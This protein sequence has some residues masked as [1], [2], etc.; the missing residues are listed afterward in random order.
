MKKIFNL[1]LAGSSLLLFTACDKYLDINDNPNSATSATPDLVLPAA[2]TAT[3]NASIG[4]S[5]YGSGSV[6]YTV[7]AGGFGGFGSFFTYNYTNTEFQGLFTGSY[8]NLRDYQYVSD[9]TKGNLNLIYPNAISRIMKSFVFERLVNTYNNVPYSEAL[10]A[11]NNLTPKYDDA[12]TIYQD[13]VNQ[14][15]TAILNIN[16]AQGL[17]SSS[18]DTPTPVPTAS[19]PMFGGNMDNWKRFANTLKL[20][21]LIK[22]SGVTAL[23]TFVTQKFNSFNTT[24]GVITDD[25]I[26][27]PGY[28]KVDGKQNPLWNAYAFTVTNVVSGAGRSRLASRYTYSFYNGTKIN[29]TRRGSVTYRA[30]P[31][32]IVNQLGFEP[33]PGALLAPTGASVWYLGASASGADALGLLKG[34][35]AGYPL[36]LASEASFLLAEAN[37]KNFV[38]GSITSALFR[39]GIEQSFTYLFKNSTNALDASKTSA[40]IVTDVSGY[41]TDNVANRLV[42]YSVAT[43]NEQRLEAIIT[44]KYVALNLIGGF[45]AWNEFRRTG[46]PS[47]VNGSTIATESFASI[48]STS[49]RP[50]RLPTRILYAQDDIQKNKANVPSGINQFTSRIFWDIN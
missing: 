14:L 30:F 23:N 25:A 48:R 32:S 5:D 13:L 39:R 41:I 7:N 45:E 8:A 36:L 29:D 46:Y 44:Q 50:D 17:L 6:G 21:L 47:I 15:D 22:M 11:S 42:N 20:R 38:S 24:L 34:A 10:K 12:A 2:I 3:A 40:I 27:Q 16:T 35:T 26:V 33:A 18:L 43:T 49:T 4:F 31:S 37:L 28:Q 1:L 9:Q 19:D